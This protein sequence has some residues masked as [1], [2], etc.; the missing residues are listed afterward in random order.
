MDTLKLREFSELREMRS[1]IITNEV[2]F[3]EISNLLWPKLHYLDH[4][5]SVKSLKKCGR[6]S[7]VRKL[8]YLNE[9]IIK[10][11]RENHFLRSEVTLLQKT[12]DF[13]SEHIIRQAAVIAGFNNKIAVSSQYS[14]GK[15]CHRQNMSKKRTA[16]SSVLK[17]A[18]KCRE[19][20]RSYKDKEN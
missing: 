12:R 1:A 10:K 2:Q 4:I 3:Y 20:N 9:S 11:T 15:S 14:A 17:K 6:S 19:K 18:K 5:V 8:K 16:A 7:T 13:L